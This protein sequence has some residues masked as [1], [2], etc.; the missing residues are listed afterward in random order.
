MEMLTG[1]FRCV[2]PP[3]LVTAL[4]VMQL[5]GMMSAYH[6]ILLEVATEMVHWSTHRPCP[7]MEVLGFHSPP[8]SVLESREILTS[9]WQVASGHHTSQCLQ[10]HL[11][12]G[13]EELV[14]HKW[15]KDS[16]HFIC[17]LI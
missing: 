1:F 16:G 12:Q 14:Y 2:T 3:S 9:C 17:L 13:G 6:V 8:L 10:T 5:L 15:W 4:S 11:S 7:S